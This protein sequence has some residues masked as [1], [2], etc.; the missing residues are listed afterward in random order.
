MPRTRDH[1]IVRRALKLTHPLAPDGRPH[2]PGAERARHMRAHVA[3][4]VGAVGHPYDADLEAIG[5]LDDPH[6][7][8][9]EIVLGA[10]VTPLA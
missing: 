5:D 3:D 8:F 1:E 7:P 4:R 9:G 6:P 10:D 2:R